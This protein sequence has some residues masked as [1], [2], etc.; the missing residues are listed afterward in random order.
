M[1]C[2]KRKIRKVRSGVIFRAAVNCTLDSDLGNKDNA[3]KGFLLC[4]KYVQFNLSVV[5]YMNTNQPWSTKI[6]SGVK[7]FNIIPNHIKIHPRHL[8]T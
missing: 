8:L 2:N 3:K 4:D 7:S 5:K 1:L 6:N